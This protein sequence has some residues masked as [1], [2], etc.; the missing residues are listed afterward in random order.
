MAKR[1]RLVL[2]T[3]P[4]LA[5]AACDSGKEAAPV[6]ATTPQGS[7]M[8]LAM[9]AIPDIKTVSAEITSRDQAEAR[10]RIPGTLVNLGVVAGDTVTTG[11][12]HRHGRRQSAGL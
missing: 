9:S 1:L 7:S 12:A 6:A 2:A 5:L 8:T 10:A 3:L 11:P 4:L